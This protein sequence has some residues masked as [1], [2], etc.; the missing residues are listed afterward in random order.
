MDKRSILMDAAAYLQSL[1]REIEQIK[2]ELSLQEAFQGST[3]TST[4]ESNSPSSDVTLPS[5][6]SS[7]PHH[8]ISQIE[9]DA[10]DDRMYV[11]KVTFQK[12]RGAVGQVQRM[13]ESLGLSISQSW[14]HEMDAD[15]MI[16]TSF[17]NVKKQTNMTT[18]ILKVQLRK[19]AFKFG[20]EIDMDD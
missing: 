10:V 20:L 19:A 8:H 5:H 4:S 3:T 15:L 2:Q 17:I 1:H 14:T 7:P 6:D 12:S 16:T 9:I 18:D 11:I 13:M